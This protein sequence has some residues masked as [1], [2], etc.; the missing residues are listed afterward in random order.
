MAKTMCKISPKDDYDKFIESIQNPKFYCK[1]CGRVANQEKR[2][3]KSEKI[4]DS[5]KNG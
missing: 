5:K 3:C 2:L 4:P 1:S